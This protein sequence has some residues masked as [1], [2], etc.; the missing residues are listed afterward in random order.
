MNINNNDFLQSLKSK[1]KVEEKELLKLQEKFESGLV[2]EEQLTE[3][4][5][6]KLEQLYNEQIN[7]LNEEFSSYKKRILAIKKQ[8]A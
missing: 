4:Q 7:K 3:E 5:V 1:E 8:L 6:V 2:T